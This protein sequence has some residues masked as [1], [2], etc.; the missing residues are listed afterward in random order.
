MKQCPSF[1]GYSATEDGRVFSHR[2]RGV[3]KLAG[4]VSTIDLDFSYELS[5]TTTAKGY[6]TVSIVLSTGKSRPLG[7]HQLVA[8]AYIGP[9][10]AGLEV[11]HLDGNP[12][13]NHRSNLAYGTS[14][15][16]AAD[17]LRHGHYANGAA[18]HN[19]KLTSTQASE[20]R[21]KRA[22]GTKVKVLAAE[23]GVSV[24]TIES[25]IYGKSYVE[26]RLP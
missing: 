8:D 7:V 16:N 14:A 3:G 2:R 10:P 18:H 22:D 23:Y 5:Q 19:A 11:R 26:Q 20:V 6:K 4:S 12:S 1:T 24:A 21:A 13:A 25:V 9:A 17:R 15:D